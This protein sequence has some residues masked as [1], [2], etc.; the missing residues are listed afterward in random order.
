ML[1]LADILRCALSTAAVVTLD[2]LRIAEPS[3]SGSLAF[4][5]VVG[6]GDDDSVGDGESVGDGVTDVVAVVGAG[7]DPIVV[8]ADDDVTDGDGA[9]EQ[10][11][12]RAA[13]A[14]A[15]VRTAGSLRMPAIVGGCPRSGTPARAGEQ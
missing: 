4:F 6:D 1:L 10:P 14:L 13:A 5:D 3:G 12:T 15:T 11:A 2:S 9:D 8:V 7:V